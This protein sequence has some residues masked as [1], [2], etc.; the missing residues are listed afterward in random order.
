M[1]Q[2]R[3]QASATNGG[4]AVA[5]QSIGHTAKQFRGC[6]DSKAGEVQEHELA[7]DR[8]SCSHHYFTKENHAIGW[9]L[10]AQSDIAACGGEPPL[11][12]GR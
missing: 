5:R 2:R 11:G 3:L 10:I 6:R 7:W 8:F 4:T 1:Q 12:P 9:R